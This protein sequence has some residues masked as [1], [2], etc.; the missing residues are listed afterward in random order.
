M[1]LQRPRVSVV[2]PTLN[3][4]PNLYHVLTYMPTIVDEVV[5]VDG[6]ST[7]NTV[8]VAQQILPSIRVVQQTR[9]GKGNA[10]GEGFAACTGDIIVMLDADGSS[11]PAEIPR[12]VDA[13]LQGCDLAKG[14][15]FVK[16]GGSDDITIVRRVGNYGL[17]I[18]VNLLFQTHFSDLC[19]GYNAFWKHCL[20]KVEIDC[21]GFEVETLLNLRTHKA[22]LKIVEVPSFERR[23]IFGTSNLRA[24]RDGWRVLKTILRERRRDNPALSRSKE[25]VPVPV[26]VLKTEDV[27]F[28]NEKAILI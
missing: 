23:R 5:L 10:L 20:D 14:S 22:G 3:E 21:D 6:F 17:S 11:D 16:G 1:Q 27:P 4:E 13:L 9:R 7:D 2:I 24:I 15:R 28:N 8:A 12:F 26:L 25:K 18:I 19:Y